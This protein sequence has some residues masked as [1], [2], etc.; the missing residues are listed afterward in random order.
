M[1]ISV[2]KVC[3]WTNLSCSFR[4]SLAQLQ[5][6][7]LIFCCTAFHWVQVTGGHNDKPVGLAMEILV[8]KKKNEFNDHKCTGIY[9]RDKSDLVGNRWLIKFI[10]NY[11][12]DL[13][14]VFSISSLVRILM[15]P[16]PAF[17]LVFVQ[18]YSCLYNKKKITHVSGLKIWIL[19]SRGK[20]I[21]K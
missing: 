7:C 14:G 4:T 10:R 11:I 13:S 15:T 9:Y 1:P 5:L 19:F 6:F 21:L 12:Q 8:K 20:N 16:F 17:T 3:I 18:K 2:N